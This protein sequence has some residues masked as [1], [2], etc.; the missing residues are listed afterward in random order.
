MRK[1]SDVQTIICRGLLVLLGLGILALG[2]GCS[3]SNLA[4]KPPSP[5]A[6]TNVVVLLTSTANEK[7]AQFDLA[8]GSVTMGDNAGNSVT[9]F[10][11]PFVQNGASGLTE[12]MRLNG[13]SKPLVTASVPQGTYT[14]ATV[15]VAYCQFAIVTVVSGGLV[16]SIDAQGLCGQGTGNTTV[17]L[18]SPI[19]ISGSA[20]A[21]SFNLHV[22]QSYTVTAYNYTISPVFLVTPVAISSNPT[23]EHHGKITGIDAQIISLNTSGNSFVAQT[24]DGISLTLATNGIT[25]YQGFT[26]LPNL[27]AGMLVNL[28]SAIQ[29]TGTL[30]ATRVGVEDSAAV[31]SD[32]VLPLSPA[33]P[34][35]TFIAEP[36][37]CF[38][39]AGTVPLCESSFLSYSG[40]VFHVSGQF[41]NL[42]NLPFTPNFSSSSFV[43][44]QNASFASTTSQIRPA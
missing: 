6:T 9:L 29:P 38:P 3:G 19:T 13:A 30:L 41:S 1:S 16:N 40:T 32:N 24:A 14:S 35:G 4:T 42:Q 20:T 28:D 7:L 25:A 44:A 37:E 17:N 10:D 12:F 36:L 39:A 23:N 5:G 43:L 8:S 22:S 15:K 26:G 33:S 27:A 31:T 18:P 34:T 21:R 2:G 11:K